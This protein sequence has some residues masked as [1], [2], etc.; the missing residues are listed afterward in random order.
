MR[1]TAD[2]P[3]QRIRAWL[4]ADNEFILLLNP[5]VELLHLRRGYGRCVPGALGVGL[6]TGI[7]SMTRPSPGWFHAAALSTPLTLAFEVLGLNRLFPYNPLNRRYRCRDLD[8]SQ[9][10]EAEQPPGA[11]LMVRREVW[12]RLGGFDT[13]LP[14]LWFE[15]VD[16]A[17][18]P[19]IWA[20][21][22]NTYP[23]LRPVAPPPSSNM[24]VSMLS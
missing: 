21:R 5:D 17:A 8:L 22:F 19:A 12:Q 13:Q 16:F 3:L 23:R 9:P 14:P 6:A 4:A 15:D 24:A 1:T 20:L 11:F 7:C 18:G 10:Q 2:S